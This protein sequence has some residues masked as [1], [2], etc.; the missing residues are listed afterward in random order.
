MFV[1]RRATLLGPYEQEEPR[2]MD[3]MVGGAPLLQAYAMNPP[4]ANNAQVC[5]ILFYTFIIDGVSGVY[6]SIF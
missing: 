4:N 3:D 1:H 5:G 6:R 2:V